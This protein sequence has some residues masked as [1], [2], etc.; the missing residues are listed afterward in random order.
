MEACTYKKDGLVYFSQNM[1]ITFSSNIYIQD[2]SI[3]EQ[4]IQSYS[5]QKF[6]FCVE[7]NNNESFTFFFR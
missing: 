1:D 2:L 5:Y 6:F 3:D 7:G 4:L